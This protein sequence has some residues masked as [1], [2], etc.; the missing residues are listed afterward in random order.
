MPK[1]G[2]K[3]APADKVSGANAKGVVVTA[4]SQGGVAADHGLQVGDVILDVGGKPVATPDEFTR[5]FPMRV[6]MASIPCYSG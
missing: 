6:R 2:F 4:I 1:L 5:R 3:L